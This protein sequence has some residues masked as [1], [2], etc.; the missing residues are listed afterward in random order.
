MFPSKF[1]INCSFPLV[2]N[3]GVDT[4]GVGG[5]GEGVWCGAGVEIGVVLTGKLI[6][7]R[8]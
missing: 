5:G 8:E 4:G 3:G 2:V 1:Y 6:G 7:A